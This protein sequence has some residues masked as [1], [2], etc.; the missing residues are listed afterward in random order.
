MSLMQIYV[1]RLKSIKDAINIAEIYNR[2]W[3]KEC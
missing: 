1:G 3:T 2:D